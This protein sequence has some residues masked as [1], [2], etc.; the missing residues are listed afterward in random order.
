MWCVSGRPEAVVVAGPRA[1]YE[2]RLVHR[3]LRMQGTKAVTTRVDGVEQLDFHKWPLRGIGD[4]VLPID[5]DPTALE[6]WPNADP[7]RVRD[8]L[9]RGGRILRLGPGRA[10]V[11]SST[12]DPMPT[13]SRVAGRCGS[14]SKPAATWHGGLA[15][16]TT[17]PGS[18][19]GSRAVLRFLGALYADEETELCTQP[20][21]ARGPAG[22]QDAPGQGSVIEPERFGLRPPSAY[23]DALAALLR[24]RRP[25]S[26]AV[27]QHIDYSVG[28]TCAALDIDALV[29][30]EAFEA[31][32][33][34]RAYG[35]ATGRVREH[36]ARGAVGDRA[37]PR[38]R[39]AARQGADVAREAARVDATDRGW[40]RDEG[41]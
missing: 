40:P 32:D 34:R 18:L 12:G 39:E 29:G 17:Y 2:A 15:R 14:F 21:L 13:G 20:R 7:A 19:I 5:V 11:R 33:V 35:V 4:V 3:K 6:T 26:R 28:T 36:G 1:R 30:G 25:P 31:R 8:W 9:R 23:V 37:V 38:R 24:R 16:G 22:V 41:S 10:H 27:F